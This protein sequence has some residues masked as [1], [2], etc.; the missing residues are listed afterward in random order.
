MSVGKASFDALL[1]LAAAT[2]VFFVGSVASAAETELSP[3]ES[4]TVEAALADTAAK[5]DP[6]PEGKTIEAIVLRPLDVLEAATD[7]WIAAQKKG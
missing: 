3:Y 1:K 6:A 4:E 7:R 5:V 2:S